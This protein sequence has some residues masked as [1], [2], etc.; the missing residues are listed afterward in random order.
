[1]KV[2]TRGD[3]A[4]RAPVSLALH[5]EGSGPTSVRDIAAR[6]AEDV[7][8]VR[9][10][11]LSELRCWFSERGTEPLTVALRNQAP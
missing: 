2:S 3:Y 5:T 1:M 4:A 10:D 7:S 11:L 9:I 8:R 6:T